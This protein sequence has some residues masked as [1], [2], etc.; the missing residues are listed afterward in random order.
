MKRIAVYC[1]SSPGRDAMY[2]DA[3]RALAEALVERDLGLVFG[4]GNVGLMG[5]LADAVLGA[6]G[7]AI[8]V[9]P[10]GLAEKEVAHLGLTKLH[11]VE[12]M[13][14]RKA[15]MSDLADGFIA[16]PG[17]FGTLD[18]MLE[19][20]TW[21]QL[22]LHRKPC[23]LLNVD[24]FFDGLARFIEHAVG[25]RFITNEHRDLCVIEEE[26]GPLLERFATY[27]APEIEKWIDRAQR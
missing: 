14:E 27:R 19:M 2:A 6:G 22:G 7:S 23:G 9:I 21:A 3:A 1:G 17:G 26:A 8:G 4:G 11:I 5:I 18:E 25:E 15:L 10:R 13:H 20:L 24:G 12:T 16:L